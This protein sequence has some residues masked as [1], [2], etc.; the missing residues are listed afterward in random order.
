MASSGACADDIVLGTRLAI[1]FAGN[2]ETRPPMVIT[3]Y[4]KVVDPVLVLV[5]GPKGTVVRAAL[6]YCYY[7]K[8]GHDLRKKEYTS[9]AHLVTNWVK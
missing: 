2:V 1:P 4:R 8:N 5:V 6:A 3:E 7:V 9:R